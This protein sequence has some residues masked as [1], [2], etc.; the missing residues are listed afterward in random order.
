MKFATELERSARRAIESTRSGRSGGGGDEGTSNTAPSFDSSTYGL[1]TWMQGMVTTTRIVRTNDEKSWPAAASVFSR[2]KLV[3][4]A[5]TRR[6]RSG[7]RG[8]GNQLSSGRLSQMEDEFITS[9]PIVCMMYTTSRLFA[10]LARYGARRPR[11]IGKA[12]A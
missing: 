5:A 4:G 3:R 10:A 6:R 9:S 1:G 8:K 11:V 2:Q 12:L 7:Y